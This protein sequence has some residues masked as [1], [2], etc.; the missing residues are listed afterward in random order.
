M[1]CPISAYKKWYKVSSVKHT[2]GKPV[3]REDSGKCYT[4]KKFNRDLKALLGPHMN[5]DQ[6]RILAHSCRS[7]LATSMAQM[8]YSDTKIQ[9]IGRWTSQAYLR[10]VK[11][12]RTKRSR[13]ARELASRMEV[14]L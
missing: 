8:G 7:G 1:F 12:A 13:I 3:F 10:Y 11:T 5:Y 2:Q 14:L 6:G 9:Q 4:G